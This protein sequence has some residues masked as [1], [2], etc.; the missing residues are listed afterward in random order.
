MVEGVGLGHG[1]E[2]FLGLIPL[3]R[4]HVEHPGLI[5]LFLTICAEASNPDHPAHDWTRHRYERTVSSGDEE[6][7][8]AGVNGDSRLF[9]ANRRTSEIRRLFALMDG[10]ELQW[11]ARPELDLVGT[12]AAALTR[13]LHRWGIEVAMAEPPPSL[14]AR[15]DGRARP[16]APLPAVRQSRGP[17]R[18]GIERREQILR[19][20]GRIF[21]RRGY[22]GT[23]LRGIA[24]EVGVTGAAILRH[25][26]SKEGLL[27]AVLERWDDDNGAAQDS[28]HRTVNEVLDAFPTVMANHPD[29]PGFVELFLTV[30]TE[31]SDPGHPA[32][33]WVAERYERIVLEVMEQL[34]TSSAEG[35]I[36]P[37]SEADRELEARCLYAVMDG[38]ELQ[39]IADPSVDL[40]GLFDAHF[41]ATVESWLT[42]A[43]TD[44]SAGHA[45]PST[46][47]SA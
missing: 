43:D 14:L 8:L 46:I 33:D 23:S 26:G 39:W 38:L 1:L 17:Y 4:Y 7:R 13:I 22:A 45:K 20:A 6:L 18:N 32:R 40:V 27:L 12:F 9:A 3:M 36:R 15:S 31:A 21:A 41:T 5:E 10:L 35:R 2:F 11:I 34:E 42:P 47:E 44:C 30:A 19:E 28:T 29:K 37:M 25:F 24:D 16:S